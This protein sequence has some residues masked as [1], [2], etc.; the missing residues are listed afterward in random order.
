MKQLTET[1]KNIVIEKTEKPDLKMW[2]ER[3]L[4]EYDL[5]ISDGRTQKVLVTLNLDRGSLLFPF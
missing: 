4:D 5:P 1:Y 3:F 2:K